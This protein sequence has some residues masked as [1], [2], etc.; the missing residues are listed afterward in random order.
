ML[1]FIM[2]VY[3]SLPKLVP[4]EEAAVRKLGVYTAK[5]YNNRLFF[6]VP[7]PEERLAEFVCIEGKENRS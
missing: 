2:L 7:N 6:W 5:I 1:G 3:C 4:A